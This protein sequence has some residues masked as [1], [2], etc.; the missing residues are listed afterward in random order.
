MDKSANICVLVCEGKTFQIHPLCWGIDSAKQT[1]WMDEVFW[2]CQVE[3]YTNRLLQKW[4]GESGNIAFLSSS[5]SVS[6]LFFLGWTLSKANE[7]Q[8]EQ[9]YAS[10]T[11]HLNPPHRFV[12]WVIVDN[13]PLQE[14]SQ[15][16]FEL[17][18]S[19]FF[20]MWFFEMKLFSFVWIRT[21]KTSW[22]TFAKL[23]KAVPHQ[24]LASL[25]NSMTAN[26]WKMPMEKVKSVMQLQGETQHFKCGQGEISRSNQ[27]EE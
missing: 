8:L 26:T 21:T 27:P 20:A 2:H 13:H 9:N 5:L 7:M 15:L 4:A 12:P 3:C 22:P 10:E 19:L 25:Y 23:T 18:L 24:K 11:T 6:F 14:V 17:V 16:Q 1:Q